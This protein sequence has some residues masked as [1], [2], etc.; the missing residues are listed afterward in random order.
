MKLHQSKVDHLNQITA[1]DH[2][3]VHVN[4]E[5]FAGSL[6]V[7]PD[8]VHVWRPSSFSDLSE[9]DFAALLE[10]KPELVLLG[11]GASIQFPHPKLYTALSAHHI[12]VDTMGTGALCRTFNVLVAEDRRVM[13]LVL[14]S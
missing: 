13:A 6:L 2:E 9:A 1:Y 3:S 14:H 8:A 7:L 12:G 5:R 11:T 4:Q 10:F